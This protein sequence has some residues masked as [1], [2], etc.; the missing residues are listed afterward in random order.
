MFSVIYSARPL[1]AYDV[2]QSAQELFRRMFSERDLKRLEIGAPEGPW[3][4]ASGAPLTT[5]PLDIPEL[6]L[7]LAQSEPTIEGHKA[8]AKKYGLLTNRERDPISSWPD[9]V[10]GM[11]RLV[12]MVEDKAN[13]EIRDR[14]L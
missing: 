3:L 10:K 13:W 14:P 4:V 5:R 8:F 9:K 1:S 12:A 2:K 6:Y 7:R 11:R